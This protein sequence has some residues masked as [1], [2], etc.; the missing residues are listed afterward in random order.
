LANQWLFVKRHLPP[1]ASTVLEIGCGP[2]GGF[3]P[4]LIDAGY[5][6]T[7]VDP[8]A[9]DAPF[10]VRIA[11]EEFDPSESADVIVACASLH[12]IDDVDKMLDHI[13]RALVPGGTLIVIE[14]AWERFDEATARWCFARLAPAPQHDERTWLHRH[15]DNWEA[16]GTSWDDYMTSWTTE[17]RLHR[18]EVIVE[19]LATRFDTRVLADAPYFF[20]ELEHTSEADEQAAVD[21][22]LIHATGVRLVATSVNQNAS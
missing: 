11:F 10:Y 15:R 17:H 16:A 19:K 18:A 21:A 2:A 9:P 14:W 4:A 6:A 8:A 22:K 12:H 3:V 20:S 13:D 1:A 5:R 7:G